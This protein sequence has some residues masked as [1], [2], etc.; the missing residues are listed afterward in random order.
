MKRIKLPLILLAVAVITIA[1]VESCDLDGNIMQ[2]NNQINNSPL[3]D[4]H[5]SASNVTVTNIRA[6]RMDTKDL[7]KMKST[8]NGGSK[9]NYKNLHIPSRA[10]LNKR[11][12]KLTPFTKHRLGKLMY[13]KGRIVTYSD[14]SEI[15][16]IPAM[17]KTKKGIFRSAH[18]LVMKKRNG[19]NRAY[20]TVMKT[21]SKF[22]HKLMH[23]KKVYRSN[24]KQIR[25][26]LSASLKVYTL[27]GTKI[28][29]VKGIRF[30]DGKVTGIINIDSDSLNN[31][32]VLAGSAVV[33][34]NCCGEIWHTIT[35]GISNTYHH[36]SHRLH[37][38][39]NCLTTPEVF[40]DTFATSVGWFSCLDSGAGI[41]GASIVAPGAGTAVMV[42]ATTVT[43][44]S[45][46]V[47]QHDLMERINNTPQ[48]Q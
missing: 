31:T 35:E 34:P 23:I 48:C 5:H 15:I 40:W 18:L 25:V 4:I 43:C 3:L 42:T 47:A 22:H 26:H 46:M 16:N 24:H 2:A 29:K 1:T 38:L 41:V 14:G 11:P 45:A 30:K 13:G 17:K 19:E 12:L 6:L 27:D 36:V 32:K 7:Q 21:N 20:L 9:H 10:N 44:G 8:Y 33:R 39:F 37:Q 28:K